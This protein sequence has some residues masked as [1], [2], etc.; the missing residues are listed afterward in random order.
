MLALGVPQL[1]KAHASLFGPHMWCQKSIHKGP[2]R[3]VC[4]RQAP[5]SGAALLP[6][7]LGRRATAAPYCSPASWQQECCHCT[8]QPTDPATD[9]S[10]AGCWGCPE[11]S[12]ADQYQLGAGT[13]WETSRV[14]Q[15]CLPRHVLPRQ[16]EFAVMRVDACSL[17]SARRVHCDH[18]SVWSVRRFV[19]RLAYMHCETKCEMK[20][21]SACRTLHML[22][23]GRSATSSRIP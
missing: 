18:M 19:R 1:C 9:A 16:V 11:L 5:V 7:S 6:V 13:R 4:R 10:P 21:A 14:F 12:I 23:R 20:N 17:A 15:A 8:G 2:L 3:I 22:C